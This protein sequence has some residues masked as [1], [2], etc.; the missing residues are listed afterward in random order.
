VWKS[1]N[2]SLVCVSSR[3]HVHLR[4]SVAWDDH[5]V[6]EV[7][8]VSLI[9]VDVLS[10]IDI[11]YNSR[12]NWWWSDITILRLMLTALDFQMHKNHSCKFFSRILLTFWWKLFHYILNG[13]KVIL[14]MK[15]SKVLIVQPENEKYPDFVVLC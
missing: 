6:S 11:Q 2:Y 8:I 4:Y 5:Y 13:C 10:F 12:T 14:G 15:K 9:D 3:C 7:I 1:H